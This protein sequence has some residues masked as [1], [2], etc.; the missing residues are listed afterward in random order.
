MDEGLIQFLVIAFFIVISMMDAAA[1]KRRKAGQ[2]PGSLPE[3]NR[4]P[5]ADDDLGEAA[6]SSEPVLPKDVWE[7][8]AALARGETPAAG[9]GQP[10]MGG[11]DS[12]R[13][14]ASEDMEWTAPQQDVP[15][16][17]DRGR[18]GGAGVPRTQ[19]PSEHRTG[20]PSEEWDT[21]EQGLTRSDDLQA[22]YLHPDQ[23]ASHEK[24]AHEKHAEIAAASRP[25]PAAA[26][27][28]PAKRPHEPV[29]HARGPT[30]DPSKASRRVGKSQSLLEGIRRG[31][32]SSLREAIILAEVLSP[33]VTLR[34]SGWKPLF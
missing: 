1:R 24:H 34:D 4:L 22:G 19:T 33:P 30:R 18:E 27:P 21:P 13:D 5:G 6:E 9:G 25:P 17:R 14:R 10:P 29:L 8:I 20:R 12:L 3:P 28:L 32:K 31:T 7:E 23:A 11:P 2:S 26:Q 15:Q 16:W